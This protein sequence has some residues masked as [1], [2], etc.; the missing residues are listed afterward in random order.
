MKNRLKAAFFFCLYYSGLEWLFARAIRVR[1]V[2]ILMYHGV[3]DRAPIPPGINF[4][5]SSRAFERQMRALKQRYDVT[6]M[7]DVVAALRSGKP[8]KKGIALTF[9]DGYRN[10]AQYVNPVLK[11]LGLPFTVFV[12]TQYIGTGL[13]MPLNQIYWSWSV[14]NLGL[15]EMRELRKQVRS[16]PVAEIPQ[17]LNSIEVSLDLASG[18]AEESFAMLSWDEI[19]DMAR[20]GVEFGS[21]TH[22]HCN[23]AVEDEQQ[24]RKE[25]L[26]SREL[27][28]QYLGKPPHLFAY[29][30]GR[31]E[32]MSEISYNNVTNSGFECAVSAEY[33]L[34]TEH[35]DRFCLPRLGYDE[36][37]WF[38]TGE[39]LYQFT[40]QALKELW[41]RLPNRGRASKA[42]IRNGDK[43]TYN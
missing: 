25:L 31:P 3:C 34:V 37:I 27:L 21:H 33:G 4:H 12:S 17:L 14:G 36:R 9:D 16:R 18:K 29:P 20:A 15:E 1:A 43:P 28:Q 6:S 24:Q 8:L 35:S 7:S 13:W 30:Y 26:L 2:A 10:N 11:R 5:L 42:S 39:I 23:M 41:S 19:R 40:K 38:F 22:S 32:N